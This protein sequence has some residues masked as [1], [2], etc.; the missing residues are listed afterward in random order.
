MAEHNFKEVEVLKN[1]WRKK[2]ERKHKREYEKRTEVRNKAK[3]VADYL[4]SSYRVKEVYLFGSLAW[5]SKFT[6]H[7]DIDIY[8]KG[9][10]KDKSFWSALAESERIAAPYPV[11]IVLDESATQSLKDKVETGGIKI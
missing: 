7:S 4:K 5:R 8:V 3:E 1:S 10:P 9:F 6:D 2:K 11:S